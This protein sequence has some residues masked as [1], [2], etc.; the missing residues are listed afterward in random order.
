MAGIYGVFLKEKETERFFEY[1]SPNPI[2]NEKV[3]L[4][5]ILGRSVIQKLENDRFFETKDGVTIC[6]EGVNLSDKFQKENAFTEYQTSGIRLINELKGSYCGFIFDEK[7]GEIFIFTD[8]LST[9]NIFYYHNEKVGFIFSSELQSITKFLSDSKISCSID[10]DAV[11]MMALYGFLLEDHTYANEIKKLHYSSVICYNLKSNSISISRNFEYRSSANEKIRKKDA[12][13]QLNSLFEQSVKKCWSKDLEYGN[14]HLSLL[15]GGLDARTNVLVAKSLRFTDIT[16]VTFGQFGSQDVKY[17]EEIAKGE[18]LNHFV[19]YL[20]N[21]SYLIDDIENNY[22]KPND[23]LMMYHTSAHTSSTIRSLN[24]KPFSLLH[25]GQIGDVL[26]GSFS[27]ENFNFEINKAKIGY[28]GN[29]RD[30]GLIDK[31]V[32]LKPILE[33]YQ[34]LGYE[35][36]SY[37]QR[38]INATIVGDRSL[39]NSIDNISPFYDLELINFCISLPSDFKKDQIIYYE[40]LKEHHK[41]ILNYSW[42]KIQMKPNKKFK[43]VYGK[44]YKKYINGGKKYFNLSYDSMNPYAIW[45]K[46]FPFI[47]LTLDKILENELQRDYIDTE[48]KSDLM[49]IYND[50]VFEFRNKFAVVTALLALKLH[51]GQ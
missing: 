50:N 4:D 6:F 36:Y 18:K 5:G 31:I 47:L 3:L 49:K 14:R 15:S 17:A 21:P 44:Y 42:E 1:L 48:L 30:K 34:D 23:G 9:K 19:R 24:L 7:K 26:L 43:M 38:Q 37:E 27:K 51:F 33:K 45:I 16:A 2:V 35:I 41:N 11:Y 20:N 29:V 25:T 8:H 22:I 40:W 39:V 28:T 12:I 46:E 10:R 13:N 32:S